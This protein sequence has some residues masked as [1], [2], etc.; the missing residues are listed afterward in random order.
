MNRDEIA[1]ITATHRSDVTWRGS[2]MLIRCTC[3][4][5]IFPCLPLAT[6]LQAERRTADPIR[7][8]GR[9]E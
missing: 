4:A 9:F 3:G 8:P 2:Q 7:N 1:L 5:D 6:A